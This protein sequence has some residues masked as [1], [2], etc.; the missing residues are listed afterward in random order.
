MR[1][2][3]IIVLFGLAGALVIPALAGELDDLY[4][5]C[6]NSGAV[7]PQWLIDELFPPAMAFVGRGS[8][9]DRTDEAG[10]I[11]FVPCGTFTDQGST[12]GY[13]NDYD[14]AAGPATCNTSFFS[15]SFDGPDIAYAFTLPGGFTVT[16]STC[17]AATFDTCLGIIDG[18]G[19]LVAVND[20]GNGCSFYSSHIS[21]CCLP[22]GDY[23]LIVDSYGNSHGNYTLNVTF[24]CEPCVV[25]SPCDALVTQEISLPYHGAGST[26]G[27]ADVYGSVAGEVAYR[28]TLDAPSMVELATCFAGT[29]FDTDSY[30]FVGGSPCEGGAVMGY[31]DGDYACGWA[32][33]VVFTCDDPLPAGTYTVLLSGYTLHEG[34]YELDIHAESC[35]LVDATEIP[36]AFSL[37]QNA[38]NPFNPTTTI[39]FSLALTGRATLTVYDLAGRAV[40]TLVDGVLEAGSHAVSLDAGRLASGVYFYALEADG[41]MATRK[42]ILMK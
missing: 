26:V 18:S 21:A 37:G 20:D 40:A 4:R 39:S 36:A 3:K 28:F 34:N 17:G 12:A 25:V 23:F 24:G 32:T 27:A 11:P 13:V 6:K 16:A 35:D 19:N 29:D 14:F 8:G 41:Q 7:A 9:G 1:P 2:G 33:H 5:S 10:V 15:Q 42:M 30:W 31:N 22:A 38:P